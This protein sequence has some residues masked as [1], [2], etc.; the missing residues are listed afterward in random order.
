MNK[1][2]MSFEFLIQS[3]VFIIYELEVIVENVHSDS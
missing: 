1:R 3:I 2:L